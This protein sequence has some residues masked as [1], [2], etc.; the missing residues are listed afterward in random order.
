M[1]HFGAL[2]NAVSHILLRA[3]EGGRSTAQFCAVLNGENPGR[4]RRCASECIF[5]SGRDETE[6]DID[7]I[8]CQVI[9]VK[10]AGKNCNKIASFLFLK[11]SLYA[12]FYLIEF[13]RLFGLCCR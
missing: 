4:P 12:T 7:S 8:N 2:N 13:A 9:L 5:I 11:E 6:S 10:Q 1:P 3:I